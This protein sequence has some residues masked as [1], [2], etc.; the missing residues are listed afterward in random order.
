MGAKEIVEKATMKDI[1]KKEAYR[2]TVRR[3]I[4]RVQAQEISN[5]F[6]ELINWVS[7]MEDLGNEQYTMVI[8]GF[9]GMS[10]DAV[11]S[12]FGK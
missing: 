10:W 6:S 5:K 12:L 8:E 11:Q 9:V 3:R 4:T 2:T 1:E 7:R